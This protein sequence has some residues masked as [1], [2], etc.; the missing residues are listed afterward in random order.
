[1]MG[2]GTVKEQ[3][4][5]LPGSSGQGFTDEEAQLQA[6]LSG[7]LRIEDPAVRS[8]AQQITQRLSVRKPVIDSTATRGIGQLVSLRYNGTSDEIDLDR[9][10]TVLAENPVPEDTDIVVRDRM[11]TKRSVVLL[12][13]VSGSMK[14]ERLKTAAA[15]VGALSAELQHDALG[16]VAFWSDA[17]VLLELGDPI[18]PMQL[19]DTILSIP[20]RGLTNVAF[21]LEV[22]AKQLTKVPARQSTVVLLSDCVHNAGPDPRPFAAVLPRLNVLLDASGEKDIE[23][24]RELASRGRGSCHVV[25]TH[26]DVAPAI[27]QVFGQQ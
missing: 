19:L 22:A 27:T 6:A 16:V 11:R 5:A 14:G 18:R 2:D 13:D 23:L 12:V 9:T 26:R 7:E 8:L 4:A 15:T 20:A 24:G 1:M 25:H 3:Q 21:P 17:A 10:I